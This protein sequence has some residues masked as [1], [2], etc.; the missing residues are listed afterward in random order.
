LNRILERGRLH[1][2][3]WYCIALGAI[4]IAWQLWLLPR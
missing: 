1:Y 3:G 4:V 2:L